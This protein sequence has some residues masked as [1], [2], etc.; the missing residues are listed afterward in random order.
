MKKIIML[1]FILLSPFILLS[2]NAYVARILTSFDAAV[3][4]GYV[5]IFPVYIDNGV[6]FKKG[7]DY[8]AMR[9]TSFDK[10]VSEGWVPMFELLLENGVAF[11]KR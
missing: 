7:N 11:R 3:S 2:E 5:P 8:K 6:V 9:L 4:S 10:M 1:S